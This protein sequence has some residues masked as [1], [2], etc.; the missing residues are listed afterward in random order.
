[1]VDV[2]TRHSVVAYSVAWSNESRVGQLNQLYDVL[3]SGLGTRIVTRDCAAANCGARF[4]YIAIVSYTLPSWLCRV[5]ST[6]VSYIQTL[7]LS[8][9]PVLDVVGGESLLSYCWHRRLRPYRSFD[10]GLVG[11]SPHIY[12]CPRH[13]RS[14]VESMNLLPT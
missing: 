11:L 6:L 3:R 10:N 8:R 5:E 14:T 7:Y 2:E 9:C 12:G 4:R 1:M 13:C